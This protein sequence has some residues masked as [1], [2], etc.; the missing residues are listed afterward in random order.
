MER[1]MKKIIGFYDYTVIFTYMGLALALEGIIQA[2]RGVFPGA[3]LLLAGALFCDTVDGKIART[4]KNRTE[5]E[6]QFGI[7]IDSLCDMVSFGVFPAV[8]FYAWGLETLID[9]VLL[10]FYCLCCVIRLAYFNVLELNKQTGEPTVYHGLPM[11]GLSIFVPAAW[12]LGLCIPPAV[13]CM[14]LRGMLV[15]FGLLYILDFKVNKP[16][17]LHL[18]IMALIFFVPLI[19]ACTML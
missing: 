2:V 3:L 10:A 15:V 14:I 4:K 16:K 7:Q 5:Q 8:I 17:L 13:F 18:A 9:F 6:K 11:V 19:I 1:D 12:L